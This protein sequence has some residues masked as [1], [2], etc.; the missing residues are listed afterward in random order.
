M[1][2]TALHLFAIDDPVAAVSQRFTLS[3]GADRAGLGSLAGGIHPSVSLR[4]AFHFF[5]LLAGF[6]GQA[7]GFRLFVL[8]GTAGKNQCQQ[9]KQGNDQ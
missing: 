6:G 3:E 7:G 4:L 5:A 9:Q 1:S 2:T 8:A